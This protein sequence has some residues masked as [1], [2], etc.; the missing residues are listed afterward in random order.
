MRAGLEAVLAASDAHQSVGDITEYAAVDKH[1][2]EE[3]YYAVNEE[4]QQV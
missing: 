3:C 1:E 2:Y 4:R